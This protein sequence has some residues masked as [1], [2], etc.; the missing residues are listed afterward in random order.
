[1]QAAGSGNK[2]TLERCSLSSN[3]ASTFGGAVAVYNQGL[4]VKDS[5]FKNN[6]VHKEV[7][8]HIV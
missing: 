2:L 5:T 3:T 7:A 4:A 8:A 1:M 6:K